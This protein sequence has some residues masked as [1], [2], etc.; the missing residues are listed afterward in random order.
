MK[1]II[2]WLIKLK[3]LIFRIL[4]IADYEIIKYTEQQ[5]SPEGTPTG[6]KTT[7]YRVKNLIG[8]LSNEIFNNP[9]EAS[10]YIDGEKK[11]NIG[12]Q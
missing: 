11:K 9:K 4:R 8:V 2:K 10:I 5:M 12:R 1:L 3:F 7:V 6:P